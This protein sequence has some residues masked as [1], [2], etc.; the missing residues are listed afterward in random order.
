LEPVNDREEAPGMEARELSEAV[1]ADVIALTKEAAEGAGGP[2]AK[3]KILGTLINMSVPQGN[4]PRGAVLSAMEDAGLDED[5]APR[6]PSDRDAFR[7]ATRSLAVSRVPMEAPASMRLFGNETRYANV[8]I[9]DARTSGQSVVRLA[10]REVVDSAGATLSH[11]SVAQLELTKDGDLHA[12]PLVARL[13]PEE[14]KIIEEAAGAYAT[15][16]T[17]H[18]DAAVRNVITRA[19][20]A[21]RGLSL[22]PSGG[23]YFVPAEYEATALAVHRFVGELNDQ[24][25]GYRTEGDTKGDA[26][27]AVAFKRIILMPTDLVDKESVRDDLAAALAEKVKRDA[28]TLADEMADLLTS[29]RKITER[30]QEDLFERVRTLKTYVSEYEGILERKMTDNRADLEVAQQ[31]A[32]KLLSQVEVK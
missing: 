11:R 26:G 12:Y 18:D 9:R 28:R 4:Y 31:Q 21:A 10:V 19:F 8:L 2:R 16:R 24:L 17:H 22:L 25:A 23:A 30:R 32:V 3:L 7:R 13:L 1:G 15:A 29:K 6:E 27:S 20:D 5:Y 14:E